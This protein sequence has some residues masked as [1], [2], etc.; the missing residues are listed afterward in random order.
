MNIN[1]DAVS[2]L[3]FIDIFLLFSVSFSI[4][5]LRLYH[6]L[7]KYRKNIVK[8]IR[9]RYVRITFFSCSLINLLLNMYVYF[10]Q[11]GTAYNIFRVFGG[12]VS[13]GFLSESSIKA[14][15]LFYIDSFSS[16]S[17]LLM[18]CIA[19]VSMFMA[20]IDRKNV[21]S[22]TKAAFFILTTCGITGVLYSNSLFILFFYLLILQVGVAGL[23]RGIPAK[24]EEIKESILFYS[25]RVV[26]VLMP[27]AGLFLLWNKYHVSNI[28][29]LAPQLVSGHLENISFI[30][31]FVPLLFIF[32]KHTLYIRDEAC[33]CYF[34]MVA[35]ATFFAV[36]RIV[37]MLYGSMP[38][39]E[40]LASL[41]IILGLG[42]VLLSVLLSYHYNDPEPYSE[43]VELYLKSTLLILLGI[44]FNGLYSAE[45]MATYGIIASEALIS[46]WLLYLPLSS[47]FTILC[48]VF[49]RKESGAELWQY[50]NL[51]KDHPYVSVLSFIAVFSV[52][53]LPPVSGYVARQFM[54]RAVCNYSPFIMMYLFISSLLILIANVRFFSGVLFRKRMERVDYVKPALV[55]NIMIPMTILFMIFIIATATPGAMFRNCLL[56]ATDKLVNREY[57]VDHNPDGEVLR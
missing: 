3:V 20:L 56:P 24:P 43:V 13:G 44:L 2:V 55:S 28:M 15:N 42:G 38:G 35:Q 6:K 23:Y 47:I 19:F 31:I 34:R 39:M 41:L 22:P 9:R 37:V 10:A 12:S 48:I 14:S 49:K 40:K 46:F 1:L 16:F 7:L 4:F 50:G 57:I 36:I 26:S 30:L 27:V 54:Y 11:K 53:G 52:A 32:F 17:A 45:G 8:N 25:T 33:R 51:A 18:A 5:A 21:L 29:I